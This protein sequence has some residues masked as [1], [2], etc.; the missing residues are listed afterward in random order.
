MIFS[1]NQ[2]NSSFQTI[3]NWCIELMNSFLIIKLQLWSLNEKHEETLILKRNQFNWK[4]TQDWA[5]LQNQFGFK[6]IHQMRGVNV[7]DV[8]CI[9]GVSLFV[10]EKHSGMIYT[11]TSRSQV[12]YS[13]YNDYIINCS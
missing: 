8:M 10:V 12:Q 9:N 5:L 13:M 4:W 6:Y 3:R 2:F 7:T 11:Y 1:L